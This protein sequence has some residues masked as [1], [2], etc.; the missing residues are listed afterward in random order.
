M[1]NLAAP[2]RWTSEFKSRLAGVSL[3]VPGTALVL[4][5][6]FHG[7]APAVADLLF[8]AATLA[9]VP[10]L[11]YRFGS[12]GGAPGEPMTQREWAILR[13]LA[14]ISLLLLAVNFYQVTVL[15]SASSIFSAQHR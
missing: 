7:I 6:R 12:R 15:L 13:P 5:L 4:V 10:G 8:A 14:A 9:T 2:S 1:Q 3:V 11:C